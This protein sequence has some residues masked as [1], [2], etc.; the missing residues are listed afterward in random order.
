MVDEVH[1]TSASY[2]SGVSEFNACGIEKEYCV[3]YPELPLVKGAP[4]QVILR[5]VN[6][7]T[8]QENDTVLVIGEIEMVRLQDRILRQNGSLNWEGIECLNVAGLEDYGKPFY[9][10]SKEYAKP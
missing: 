5:Y 7:Y 4:I 8:I 6:A 1:Q 3:A 9:I 10:K 2:P